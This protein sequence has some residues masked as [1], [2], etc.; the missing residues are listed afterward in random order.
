MR[1]AARPDQLKI[2][3]WY[4]LNGNRHGLLSMIFEISSTSTSFW[5]QLN[6]TG[7]PIAELLKS[8][9]RQNIGHLRVLIPWEQ[10]ASAALEFIDDSQTLADPD[11]RF[12]GGQLMQGPNLGYPQILFSHRI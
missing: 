10:V 6:L 3:G 4:F 9:R 12:G 11:L 1:A 5:Y 7:R 2:D 8:P